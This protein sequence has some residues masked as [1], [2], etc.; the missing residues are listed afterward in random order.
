MTKL[1][2][3]ELI[4]LVI[5]IKNLSQSV[6]VMINHHYHDNFRGDGFKQK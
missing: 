4:G 3:F 1:T 6:M 5:F 2:L